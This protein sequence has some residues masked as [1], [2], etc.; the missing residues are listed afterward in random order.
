MNSYLDA[1]MNYIKGSDYLYIFRP[2]EN[3][4]KLE[5][6]IFKKIPLATLILK[7]WNP[8]KT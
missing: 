6:R 1:V 7:L 5:Q 4:T 3:K 8:Q 2:A